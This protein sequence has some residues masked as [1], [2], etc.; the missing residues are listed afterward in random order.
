MVVYLRRV[1]ELKGTED[2]KLTKDYAIAFFLGIM[3][4]LNLEIKDEII[5]DEFDVHSTEGMI[6]IDQMSRFI[7]D[8]SW[9]L[10]KSSNIEFSDDE[11]ED[12][13]KHAFQL[14]MVT[15]GFKTD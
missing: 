14:M 15:S 2:G 4:Y 8:A 7:L 3:K 1:Y 11:R 10:A 12:E 13:F 6:D 5:S 9:Q